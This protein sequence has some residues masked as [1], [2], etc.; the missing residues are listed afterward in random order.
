MSRLVVAYEEN[1]YKYVETSPELKQAASVLP[2]FAALHWPDYS[3]EVVEDTINGKP[4]VIQ[5]WKGWCPQLFSSPDFP[6][7][8]GAEVG[9]YE[10]V[11]GRGF[12][13]AKPDTIPE[14]MWKFLHEASKRA[15]GDFWWPVAELNEIEFEFINPVTKQ[16]VFHAG[17]Q[18]TYWLTKWMDT[19]SYDDYQRAQGKRWSWL[20]A[21]F[22]KNS[23]TPPLSAN[24]VLAYKINGKSYPRW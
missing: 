22:P 5:L 12:P 21:G 1:G 16:T 10:R 17:P 8:I 2:C 15:N 13:T 19:G 6:G 24:Y 7:G 14:P 18:K 23:R 9:I 3:T 4:V 11:K 20:P